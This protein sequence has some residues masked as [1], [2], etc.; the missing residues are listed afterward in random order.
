MKVKCECIKPKIG[1]FIKSAQK[2]NIYFSK[3]SYV[4]YTTTD[5]KAG[6]NAGMRTILVHTGEGGK[7]RKFNVNPHFETENFLDA[8]NLIL[9]FKK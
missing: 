2:Y 5:I 7:D 9:N 4:V 3:S 1:M 6:I 8:A